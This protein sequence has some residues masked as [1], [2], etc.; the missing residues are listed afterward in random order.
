MHNIFNRVGVRQNELYLYGEIGKGPED[1]S[2][3]AFIDA[4]NAVSANDEIKIYINSAGGDVFEAMAIV[5]TMRRRKT[6]KTVIVDGLA[7]SAASVICMAADRIVM[8]PGA[9]MM[10]HMPFSFVGGTAEEFRER[11]K[12]L[13]EATASIVSLYAERTGNQAE[14][15]RAWMEAETWMNAET[16][17][18]RG[19]CD[20]I[21]G[22]ETAASVD[23]RFDQEESA[24]KASPH[25][26]AA[27]GRFRHAPSRAFCL[28]GLNPDA[29]AN[30][31]KELEMK[32][33]M[34]ALGLA[35][36]AEEAKAVER[37]QALR[38]LES[39]TLKITNSASAA[40]ALKAVGQMQKAAEQL[41]A[42][43]QE[44][45]SLLAKIDEL[46]AARASAEVAS[47]IDALRREGKIVPAQE[48][49]ASDLGKKDLSQLKAFAATAPVIVS[50]AA[51]GGVKEPASASGF[52]L[53]KPFSEMSADEKAELYES[54]HELYEK[55]KN[56]G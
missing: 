35:E 19:F 9:M 44:K 18:E 33:I 13:D 39:D 24:Q 41:N 17:K 16:A 37:I 14:Q 4:L 10:I 50:T 11:A 45:A 52:G 23:G 40:D 54:N 51:S 49:W 25:V 3:A 20:A 48:Q 1:I 55:L 27:L 36:D 42:L 28:L 6:R 53:K 56:N 30:S 8:S 5:A 43:T 12:S 38:A 46:E 34:T 31:C 26:R 22:K 47:I 15:V 7:A 32:Q 21:E 2:A 29:A